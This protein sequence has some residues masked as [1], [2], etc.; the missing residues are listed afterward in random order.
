MTCKGYAMEPISHTDEISISEVCISKLH[1]EAF[2]LALCATRWES[3][4]CKRMY[5][6]RA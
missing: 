3:G 6:E 1:M 4:D 5:C 2:Y